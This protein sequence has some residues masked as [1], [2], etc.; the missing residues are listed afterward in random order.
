ME[1]KKYRRNESESSL[2]EL[3]PLIDVI[4]LLLIFFMIT[5]TF[6]QKEPSINIKLPTSSI[7]E[8][9]ET[10]EVVVTITKNKKLYIN[11]K[12]VPLRNFVPELSKTLKLARKPNV[13]IRGDKDLDYGFIVNI[14][15]LCRK[16]GARVLDIATELEKK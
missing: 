9:V 5:T 12:Q 1:I 14:M 6:R 15:T 3:T 11:T 13:I 4:F 10:K 16:S 8:V 2:L 7:E